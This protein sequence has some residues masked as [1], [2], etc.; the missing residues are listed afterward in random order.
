M[1]EFV[2]SCHDLKFFGIENQLETQES[3]EVQRK[4]IKDAEARRDHH[5]YEE[6]VCHQRKQYQIFK[7]LFY[8]LQQQLTS[9]AQ[10]IFF[11]ESFEF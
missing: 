6:Q 11:K 1:R 9:T 4:V 8:Q 7:V 10:L 5:W 3:L 2:Y